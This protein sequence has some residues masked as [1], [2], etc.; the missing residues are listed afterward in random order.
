[1]GGQTYTWDNN[2]NLL[3]DGT[4]TYTYNKANRLSSVTQV[5]DTYSFVYNGLGDRLQQTVNAQTTTYTLDLHSN[6]TQVLS[7]GTSSYVYGNGHIA[8]YTGTDFAYYLADALGSVRQ[9][10]NSTAGVTLTNTYEPYG[11]LWIS[12]GTTI[13]N[14]GFAGEWTDGT[15]LQHLRARYLDTGIGRFISRDVWGGDYNRPMSLN[16]WIYGYANPI[17]LID[18][19]GFCPFNTE[20]F[21]SIDMCWIILNHIE[22]Q[23]SYIDIITPIEGM[24]LYFP[25][26]A[27]PWTFSELLDI[28]KG[29]NALSKAATGLD[30]ASIFS[31]RSIDI[32]RYKYSLYGKIAGRELCGLSTI[33]GRIHFYDNWQTSGCTPEQTVVHEIGHKWSR[34]TGLALDFMKYVGAY[35]D[36]TG[37]YIV[38]P[39]QPPSY[40]MAGVPPDHEED[41]AESLEEYVFFGTGSGIQIKSFESRYRFMKYLLTTGTPII[42][43]GITPSPPTPSPQS[44]PVPTPR[45]LTPT[46]LPDGFPKELSH[47]REMLC[48]E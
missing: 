17:L 8:E 29:L 33:G 25:N 6:L 46:Y 35:Y 13:S 4:S 32:V 43:P 10:V 23:Y 37:K 36:H 41:F 24:H 1:V 20:G 5:T 42:T 15:G 9:I 22:N 45:G 16:K 40:G 27:I 11:T 34:K 21:N 30:F 28:A 38:G 31:P 18:P 39:H 14:Y 44:T 48:I 47:L 7:D 2:G 19:L 12:S 3:S 26:T